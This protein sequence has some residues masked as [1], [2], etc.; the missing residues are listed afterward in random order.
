MPLYFMIVTTGPTYLRAAPKH[1]LLFSRKN[2]IAMTKF[3]A[4]TAPPA[5]LR[6]SITIIIM[7]IIASC[8]DLSHSLSFSRLLAETPSLKQKHR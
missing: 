8:S 5:R 2:I 3:D 1:P 7:I 6:M 4:M